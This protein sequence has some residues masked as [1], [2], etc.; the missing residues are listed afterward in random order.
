MNFILI[1]GAYGSPEENWLPWLKN[2]LEKSGHNVFAP[3]FP[4]PE[5][6]TLDNWLK[7]IEKYKANFNKDCILV[8]H[9]IGCAFIFN[10]L[11]RLEQPIKAA[12]LVAGFIGKLSKEE[13]DKINA[14]FAE[15]EFDWNKIRKNC[16]Q[17]YLYSSEDDPYVPISKGYDL[18]IN[19]KVEVNDYFEKAGHFNAAAGYTKFPR[20]LDDIKLV[21]NQSKLTIKNNSG[22]TLVGF[23][24]RPE[25][26]QE[27]YPAIILAHGFGV[28]KYEGGMFDEITFILNNE[29]FSV[30]R[31][32]FSG[33]GESDGDY[34]ETSLT[35]LKDD[36][37]SILDFVRQQKQVG[38]IGVL[39]QSFG[40]AT[41]IAL[42]PAVECIALMGSIAHPK[43]I[44]NALFGEN[45]NP[46]GISKRLRSTGN[47]TYIKPQFWK[48]LDKYNLLKEIKDIQS[49]I[50]FIHG[51]ADEK[52]PLSEGK[53]L[54]ENA[55]E[56]KKLQEITGADHGYEHHR[57]EMLSAI[58]EWFGKWL[59]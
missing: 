23:T 29:G 59:K 32:D 21:L 45:Y 52:V 56:P 54:Y 3:Q 2:E 6:Q 9:S 40:T 30:Y 39:G 8:G 16:E 47:W 4:T 57:K 12:F 38:K 27:K 1:H 58:K 7:V 26:Q 43:E 44:I 10:V 28:T 35:K 15:R 53:A 24:S 19:L 25:T 50:L 55:N 5:G 22:E 17:F 20:L 34:N 31:F 37:A 46:K 33:C 42:K 11:E 51:T 18:A 48:D 14:S 41:I 13:F 36:L 49:P